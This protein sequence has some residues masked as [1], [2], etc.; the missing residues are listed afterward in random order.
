MVESLVAAACWNS[1][2]SALVAH[3][4]ETSPLPSNFNPTL[5]IPTAGWR[6]GGVSSATAPIAAAT[7]RRLLGVT[8][9]SSSEGITRL[10]P[11][12]PLAVGGEAVLKICPAMKATSLRPHAGWRLGG[13]KLLGPSDSGDP[14]GANGVT[15][16]HVGLDLLDVSP[17]SL[18]DTPTLLGRSGQFAL[19]DD[20]A[21]QGPILAIR[22]VFR[23]RTS[24]VQTT[25]CVA[26]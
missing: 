9:G 17:L 12:P 16:G 20:G 14:V 18:D 6:L 19:P 8:G 21:W 2:P 24:N 15:S 11:M 13:V 22:F 25:C 3:V 7:L 1:S 5:C 4:M 26:L 10:V 23:F